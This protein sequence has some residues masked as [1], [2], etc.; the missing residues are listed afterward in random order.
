MAKKLEDTAKTI[1]RFIAVLIVISALGYFIG[2]IFGAL[3]G[4][5]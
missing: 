1:F 5:P 3:V 2:Q 4:G